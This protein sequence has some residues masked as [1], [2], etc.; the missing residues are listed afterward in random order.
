MDDAAVEPF[1]RL[2]RAVEHRRPA[3]VDAAIADQVRAAQNDVREI[4]FS[5]QLFSALGRPDLTFASLERYFLDRGSFGSRAPIGPY[6]RR[7]TDHLFSAPMAPIRS[8]RRF[9]ELTSAIG[10]DAYW[11]ALGKKAPYAS[12]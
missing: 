12:S 6:T 2:A 5:A 1:A 9:A 4:A 3:D 7:Y 10:L 11:K 8:D